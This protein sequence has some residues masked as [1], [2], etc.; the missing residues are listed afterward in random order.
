MIPVMAMSL[1]TI[2][3]EDMVPYAVIPAITASGLTVVPQHRVGRAG[4][5]PKVPQH[6][7]VSGFV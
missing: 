1:A 6:A 2:R 3:T 5:G 4:I 7:E